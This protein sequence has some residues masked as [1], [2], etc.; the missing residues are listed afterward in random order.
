MGSVRLGVG[1]EWLLDGRLFRI[2][3]QPAA[4]RFVVLDL[5]FQLEQTLAESEILGK[6]AQGAL[7]FAPANQDVDEV[8]S[9]PHPTRTLDTLS[10][11]WR[12]VPDATSGSTV[13][14]ELEPAKSRLERPI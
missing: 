6:Y 14:S 13:P 8:D 11:E 3:R 4:N 5:K 10:D 9:D 7:R 2:V 1:T 12:E